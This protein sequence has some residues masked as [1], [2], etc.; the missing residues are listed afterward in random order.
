MHS[1]NLNYSPPRNRRA[2]AGEIFTIQIALTIALVWVCVPL[3]ESH[4][5]IVG[6]LIGLFSW[7]SFLLLRAL[8]RCPSNEPDRRFGR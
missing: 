3:R 1:T 6:L 4:P 8:Y 2:S 7:V 5:L